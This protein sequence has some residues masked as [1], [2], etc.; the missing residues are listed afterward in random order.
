MLSDDLAFQCGISRI[1]FRH[2]RVF[3]SM[4]FQNPANL[5]YCPQATFYP[6]NQPTKPFTLQKN[7]KK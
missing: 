4:Q 3:K 5:E 1:R 7:N 6:F 2:F